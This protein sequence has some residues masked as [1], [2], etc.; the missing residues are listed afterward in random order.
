VGS[1]EGRSPVRATP[2]LTAP[3]RA[4]TARTAPAHD[5]TT[6]TRATSVSAPAMPTTVP[7]HEVDEVLLVAAWFKR[8]PGELERTVPLNP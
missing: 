1:I 5:S 7:G 4:T 6:A 2:A 8:H 3:T